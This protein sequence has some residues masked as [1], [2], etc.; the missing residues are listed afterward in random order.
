MEYPLSHE[1]SEAKLVQ[2]FWPNWKKDEGG[3]KIKLLQIYR[4]CQ[5]FNPQKFIKNDEDRKNKKS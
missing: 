2:N 3:R 1:A 5:K 4:Y